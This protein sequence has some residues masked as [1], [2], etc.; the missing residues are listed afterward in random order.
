VERQ[1]RDNGNGD[2]P[3]SLPIDD[4]MIEALAQAL[5]ELRIEFQST[6]D[7][8]VGSLTE[9]VATLRGQVSVLTSLVGSLVG[10]SNA[11]KEASETKTKTVRRVRQIESKHDCQ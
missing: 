1:S 11:V 8:A 6:I 9:Q 4:D 3:P 7:D 10:N 5:A 2:E